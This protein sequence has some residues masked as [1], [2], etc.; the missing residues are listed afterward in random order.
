MLNTLSQRVEDARLQSFSVTCEYP[1]IF[2]QDV[3]ALG[4][5][6][7]VDAVSLRKPRPHHRRLICVDSGIPDAVPD[8]EIRMRSR[9]A[10]HARSLEPVFAPIATADGKAC[11]RGTIKRRHRSVGK[12]AGIGFEPGK[13]ASAT[14]QRDFHSLRDARPLFMR[15][16]CTSVKS[17]LLGTLARWD[18]RGRA[19][20]L[21]GQ[22]SLSGSPAASSITAKRRQSASRS[23]PSGD[24]RV[25]RVLG[26]VGF[27]LWH[28]ELRQRD[29][30]GQPAIVKGLAECREHP[31]ANGRSRCVLASTKASKFTRWTI[32]LS[33]PPS[34]GLSSG[35]DRQ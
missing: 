26:R 23:I 17:G 25:A 19:I 5:A 27:R 22:S 6:C 33:A 11:R 9:A 20:L 3:F 10:A 28:D 16:S 7:L 32:G 18:P 8:L 29:E 34:T 1:V 21:T 14:D 24:E 15:P 30:T 31:G 4:N 2:T 12:R 13:E 35:F